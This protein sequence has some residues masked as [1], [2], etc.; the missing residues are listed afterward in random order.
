[1]HNVIMY[2]NKKNT[3][4]TKKLLLFTNN[5]L[6]IKD[7]LIKKLNVNNVM[8]GASFVNKFK[9]NELNRKAMDML[10]QIGLHDKLHT[11]AGIKVAS[12]SLHYGMI[13]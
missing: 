3:L 2:V 8:F 5:V 12:K 11:K 13:Q 6:F 7:L 10:K 9:K 4:Y 1:M